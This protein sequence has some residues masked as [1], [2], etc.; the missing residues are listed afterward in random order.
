M[1]YMD[2][3]KRVVRILNH[4]LWILNYELCILNHGLSGF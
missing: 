2:F 3:E 4:E 1:T